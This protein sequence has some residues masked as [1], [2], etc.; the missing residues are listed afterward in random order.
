MASLALLSACAAP[1]ADPGSGSTSSPPVDPAASTSSTPAEPTPKLAPPNVRF[2][3]AVA[4]L[5]RSGPLSYWYE[6]A[7]SG[8]AV[9]RATGRWDPV[10]GS[11]SLLVTRPKSLTSDQ[12]L[13]WQLTLIGTTWYGQL[14]NRCWVRANPDFLADRYQITRATL[15]LNALELLA[16][17]RVS[18]VAPNS[19]DVLEVDFPLNEVVAMTGVRDSYPGRVG[20]PGQVTV[21]DGRI[22][23]W[24]V[25]GEDLAE[26]YSDRLPRRVVTALSYISLE[27]EFT[28]R[29]TDEIRRPARDKLAAE[30]DT[31]CAAVTGSA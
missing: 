10:S 9:V 23:K 11:A 13:S 31:L 2:A 12:R 7:D 27:M 16:G 24:T 26:R 25:G 3:K 6:A 17:A 5:P 8:V 4:A 28:H 21:L 14:S 30:P 22:H 29:P 15:G 20:V 19:Q 18:G 1:A